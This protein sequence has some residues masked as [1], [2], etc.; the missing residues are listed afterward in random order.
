M[1]VL[2]IEDHTEMAETVAVGLRRA[3]MTDDVALDEPAGRGSEYH[4]LVGTGH[5][6]FGD[7]GLAR[8]C[9]IR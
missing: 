9:P 6:Q 1:R 3:Q 4:A 8:L 2:V 5:V 7:A